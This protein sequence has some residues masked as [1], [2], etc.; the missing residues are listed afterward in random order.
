MGSRNQA[1]GYRLRRDGPTVRL[2][3]R[4][5]YDWTARLASIAAAA[6]RIRAKSTRYGIDEPLAV[7]AR[8]G[9]LFA[10]LPS[11]VGGK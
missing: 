10:Y 3:S 8:A 7:C 2:Y 5:A 6:Q 1:C 11:L 4:N 9:A